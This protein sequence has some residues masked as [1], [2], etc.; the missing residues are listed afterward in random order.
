[1]TIMARELSSFRNIASLRSMLH[2]PRSAAMS[3]FR[4]AVTVV[5][6][7]F[8]CAGVGCKGSSAASGPH[9]VLTCDAPPSCSVHLSPSANV[10]QDVQTALINQA[11]GSTICF[12]DGVYSFTDQLS[13]T[14][15]GITLRGTSCGAVFD[16][17]NQ[18]ATARNGLLATGDDFTMD[19]ITIKNTAGDG[20]RVEGAKNVTLRRLSVA[21]D[22][23]A[24]RPDD[25]G[26]PRSGAYA[27]YPV[28][29]D[30]VTIDS[31]EV[32]G[33]R[34]AALYVGQS[35]HIVVKNS[36][37]H[38]NVAGIEIENSSDAE[39]F[40]NTTTDNT[41]GILVFNLPDLPVQDGRRTLV[42]DNKIDANNRDNFGVTGTIVASVPKGIG[43]VIMAASQTEV[44]N[45]TVTNNN[46][47]G[48][49][50]VS[51]Y[52]QNT[53]KECTSTVPYNEFPQ[54]EFVHD[55]SFSA[56]GS[57]PELIFKLIAGPGPK[58]DI[59]WDGDVDP[60]KPNDPTL[61]QCIV[62]N[63]SATFRNFDS[64]HGAANASTDLTPYNCE[65]PPLPAITP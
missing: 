49:L 57:D 19:N 55:N 24:L 10:Q 9:G 59:M 54:S 47:T 42:H 32:T 65:Y 17:R 44:R 51:C 64:R 39:V 43:I 30:G 37:V 53:L 40:G 29:C 8:A 14:T 23:D 21:W 13:V 16:F 20:I 22:T 31:C 60:A 33:A 26:T 25:A 63:G 61:R 5:I 1:M 15:R 58:E 48:L 28:T 46:S 7:L 6:A 34:D 3:F 27:V 2:A 36:L 56:N 35:K 41:A 45:N 11:S 18:V 12:D 50:I 52:T 38:G 62:R 4:T